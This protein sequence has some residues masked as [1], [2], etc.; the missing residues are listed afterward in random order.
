[1]KYL[2]STL[3]KPEKLIQHAILDLELKDQR[4][5]SLIRSYQ[6]NHSRKQLTTYIQQIADAVHKFP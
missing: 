3:I 5:F 1:M 2:R 6:T 4:T